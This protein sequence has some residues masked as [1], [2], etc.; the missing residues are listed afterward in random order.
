V[1]RYLPTGRSEIRKLLSASPVAMYTGRAKVRHRHGHT[2]S[3]PRSASVTVPRMSAVVTCGWAGARRSLEE[4]ARTAP[5]SERVLAIVEPTFM[6]VLRER[7][8][9]MILTFPRV[10]LIVTKTDR[11]F[12]QSS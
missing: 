8:A 2:G 9:G 11:Q 10:G 1:T 7:S 5:T 12:C 6:F 4:A 3:S